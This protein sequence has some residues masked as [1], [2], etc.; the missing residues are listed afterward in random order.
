M[1]T[2][3]DDNQQD[4]PELPVQAPV[5]PAMEE[6]LSGAYRRILRVAIALSVAG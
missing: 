6:R 2:P 4:D 3:P 1:T 5:D